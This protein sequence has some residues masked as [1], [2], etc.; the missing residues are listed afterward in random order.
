MHPS[1][2][3]KTTVV[4]PW[5]WLEPDS[6]LPADP[7]LRRRMLRVA[8]CI[9]Y[10]GPMPRGHARETLIACRCRPGNRPCPGLLW[11][12]KQSDDAILAFCQVCE[13]DEFLIYEWE[14]TLWAEG[15]MES[16]DIAGMAAAMDRPSRSPTPDDREALLGRV[17]QV[18]G[19]S[20][21]SD[22]VARLVRE[23]ED[24]QSVIQAVMASTTLP[25]EKAAVERF[26]PLLMDLW[27]A[28]PRPR[29]VS[30][31]PH[32]SVVHPSPP[33][34]RNDPCPCGSGRKYKR[35]C[36]RSPSG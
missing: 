13:T 30:G 23:A 15:P 4:N 22:D 5:H 25:P 26:L 14:D 32:L 8:Q 17:L 10:G 28:T 1:A 24:P 16:V 33:A 6:S 21:D 27:N 3:V 36:L 34:A 31:V 35:C 29:P 20:L 7:R 18:M 2:A 11:V 9:E 12:L 19:S